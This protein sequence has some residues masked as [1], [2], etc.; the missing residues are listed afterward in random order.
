MTIS[1]NGRVFLLSGNQ[2]HALPALSM[3]HMSC[4]AGDFTCNL[5]QM[6]SQIEVVRARPCASS[7]QMHKHANVRDKFAAFHQ[8]STCILSALDTWRGIH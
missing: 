5:P 3:R 6:A 2:C 1:H 7:K 8:G 4:T